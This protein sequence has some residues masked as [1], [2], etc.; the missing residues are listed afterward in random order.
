[1]LPRRYTDQLPDSTVII[2]VND[3]AWDR[4]VGVDNLDPGMGLDINFHK[5]NL[6]VFLD[7]WRTKH[8]QKKAFKNAVTYMG[9]CVILEF[10]DA[11]TAT[12]FR[13]TW[14]QM[15]GYPIV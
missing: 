3:P 14:D 15:E 1:M 12:F 10:V 7:K 8:N 11:K 9:N 6:S 2:K 4:A 13:L 5:Q